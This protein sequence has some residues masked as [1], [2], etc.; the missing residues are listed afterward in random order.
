MSSFLLCGI[1]T[2]DGEYFDK[3]CFL[4]YIAISSKLNVLILDL[5]I[6]NGKF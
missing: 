1:F 5:G 4:K 3:I 6:V 2:N